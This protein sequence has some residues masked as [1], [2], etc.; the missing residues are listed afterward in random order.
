MVLRSARLKGCFGHLFMHA[1]VE[2]ATAFG[3][4]EPQPLKQSAKPDAPNVGCDILGTFG[5]RAFLG[6][7]GGGIGV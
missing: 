3:A 2:L 6:L 1:G 5:T 4:D 7:R